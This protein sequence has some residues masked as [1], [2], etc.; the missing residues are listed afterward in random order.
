VIAHDAQHLVMGTME[1]G[2][3]A[4]RLLDTKV[5]PFFG[6]EASL[7]D[8]EV[9]P[10]ERAGA[11]QGRERVERDASAVPVHR[12][13]QHTARMGMAHMSALEKRDAALVAGQGKVRRDQG[14]ARTAVPKLLEHREALRFSGRSANLVVGSEAPRQR[15]GNAFASLSVGVDEEQH[16]QRAWFAV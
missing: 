14:D 8:P 16:R 6:R 9:D 15:G 11:L 4:Q 2:P 5:K 13:E 12:N 1:P 10:V 3:A 7:H